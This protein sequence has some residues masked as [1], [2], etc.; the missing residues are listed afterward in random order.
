LPLP[1]LVGLL[2]TLQRTDPT[3]GRVALAEV[4]AH[5]YQRRAAYK[6]LTRLANEEARMAASMPGLASFGRGLEWLSED[7]PLPDALR[8]PVLRMRDIS[9]EVAS[10]LE[11][12]SAT[13][14]VRRLTAAADMLELLRLQP[15][16]FGSALARWSDII[17]AGLEEARRQQSV[18]EPIPQVYISDGRPIRPADRPESASP[19]KGRETLFRQLEAALGG[20]ESERVTFLLYG[21][22]RTGKTSV[23]LHLPRRLGSRMVPAFLDLQSGKLGGA[24]DVAGLLSGLAEEVVDEARRHRGV[25]LPTMDRKALSD[26]PYPALGRWLDQ[27]ESAL[28]ERTLLLGLDEFE[29]LEGAIQSGRL[30]T[31]ILSTLR[32]IVQHRRR[33][34]VLLSGSH[35]IDELPP[36]WASALIT[37]TT[38]PISFLEEADARKL[39][40]EPVADFPAIYATAAIDRIMQVT[41]CQP[42]LVQLTCALLVGR[43]NAARRMPPDSFVEAEDVDAMIPLALER[44]QNYF[45]N[46]WRTQTGSDVARRVLQARAPGTQMDRTAIRSVERDESALRQAVATLLRREIIERTDGGYRITVPLVAEYVRRQALV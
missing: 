9:R 17:A 20:A 25:S 44:G 39:I 45:I 15:G 34:V 29:A 26:D 38:L 27:V 22:R 4:A 31:R 16:E 35:Q 11:S 28:G 2:T 30:D 8:N 33:I 37:T 19:F 24:K 3:L 40:E 1:G 23:L 6:A 32:N 14:R 18:E 41:H 42:Y 21:Q 5:R 10:A 36:H 46:L 13:N 43:M 12:D 7:M